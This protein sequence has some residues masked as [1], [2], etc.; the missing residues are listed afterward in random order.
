MTVERR[1]DIAFKIM[2]L[3]LSG[4]VAWFSAAKA[5]EVSLARVETRMSAVE[6]RQIRLTE[7]I[8][9]LDDAK[10]GKAEHTVALSSVTKR[11]DDI[12]ATQA[13]ILKVMLRQE[14]ASR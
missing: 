10:V 3:V 5:I 1:Q 7:M 6:A 2:T 12:Q 13:E 14:R 4:M 11:L 9:N 8:D